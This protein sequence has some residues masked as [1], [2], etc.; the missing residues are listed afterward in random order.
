MR[1]VGQEPFDEANQLAAQRF[2]SHF[3]RALRMQKHTQNLQTKAELGAMAIDALALSILIVDDNGVILHLNA[4]AERLLNSRV[5]GLTGKAGRLSTA[6]PSNKSKLAAL[7][8][9]ATGYPAVGG[10]MF[11]SGEENRQLFV[12]PLPAASPFALDWQTPL[13]LVMVLEPGN[14]MSALQ[15]QGA[16]YDL[17]PAELRI[18]AALLAGK[19]PEDYA[20]EAGV[21]MNTVRTQLKKLF[22]KTDTRRQSELVAVLS[23]APPLHN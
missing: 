10:A 17:S 12:T 19:S 23:K 15:L 18:A 22:I 6:H 5:S 2:G 8:A 21:T 4:G 16:L 20:L 1:A 14:N 3:Q 11:L 7:I 13:A 9:E